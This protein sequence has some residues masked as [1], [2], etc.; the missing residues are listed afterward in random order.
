M[1]FTQTSCAGYDREIRSVS[2]SIKLPSVIRLLRRI[3]VRRAMRLDAIG[4]DE[5][6]ALKKEVERWGGVVLD[7]NPRTRS[8]T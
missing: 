6:A 5:A 3:R 2:F 7:A 8:P 4:D 1:R